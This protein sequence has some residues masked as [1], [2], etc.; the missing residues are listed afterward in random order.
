MSQY[1]EFS[2]DSV[3]WTHELKFDPYR[4]SS[5]VLLW[6]RA[7]A[8]APPSDITGNMGLSTPG[9][10]SVGGSGQPTALYATVYPADRHILWS[11]NFN[12]CAAYTTAPP[13]EGFTAYNISGDAS[14]WSCSPYGRDPAQITGE[15]PGHGPGIDISPG[16]NYP[17][18][19]TYIPDEDW[20]VSP[21]FDLSAT[22]NPVLNFWS[23]AGQYTYWPLQLKVSTDY[24]GSGDP[25]TAHWT[26]INGH[27][28]DTLTDIWTESSNIDL[29]AYRQ[30]GVYF[31]YVFK[32]PGTGAPAGASTTLSFSTSTIP[33]QP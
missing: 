22:H 31:A 23:R 6:V 17:V 18:P 29:S 25:R 21:R 13:G 7:T 2:R 4:A 26:N 30:N 16:G 5:P 32:A 14:I 12:D 3:N 28:P 9:Q 19:P 1:F 11:T 20:L 33:C 15:R 8:S 27:F 10:L 24:T